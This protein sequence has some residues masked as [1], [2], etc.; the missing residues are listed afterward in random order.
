MSLTLTRLE[1]S[2]FLLEADGVRVAC[3]LY[4]SD[5]LERK[6]RGTD[7]PHVRLHPPTRDPRALTGLDWVFASHR[8]SDHLDPGSIRDVLAASPAATL[9]LPAPLVDYAR[10]E[11]GV[12][13]R[14]LH[15]A[16]PGEQ[17]GPLTLV[18]AAHPHVGDE[19]LSALVDVGGVRVFHS[20]DTLA[21]DEQRQALAR[22]RPDV[23]LLPANGRVAEHLGT[24]P[25]MTLEEALDLARACGAPLVIPHHYDLFAFNSRDASDVARVL[26]ASGLPHRQLGPDDTI[27]LRRV[28]GALRVEA[29]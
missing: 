28:D 18:P 22:E 26:A 16:R 25:N 10:V 5:H 27:A 14:R 13:E 20:G 23:V 3:D 4:L 11:L 17:V 12:D 15:G 19:F 24:P 7:K 29:S 6:Y 9:V 8:H 2:G 1:Q 21:F